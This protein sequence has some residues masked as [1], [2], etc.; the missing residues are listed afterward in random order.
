MKSNSHKYLFLSGSP[1]SGTTVLRLVLSPHPCISIS[2]ECHSLQQI[3]CRFP[4]ERLLQGSELESLKRTVLEDQKLVGWK[5]NVEPYLRNVRAYRGITARKAA[6]DMMFYYRDQTARQAHIV[7]N[8][9]GLFV[10]NGEAVHHLFP[11]ARFI[12][13]TR[14]VRDVR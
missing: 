8:K 14:D 10:E 13:I 2:P 5:I 1:R 4:H 11:E 3:M 9:K 7:G 12:F 6:E